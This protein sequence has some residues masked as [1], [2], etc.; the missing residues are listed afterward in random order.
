MFNVPSKRKLRITSDSPL[1]RKTTLGDLEV[2]LMEWVRSQRPRGRPVSVEDV[3]KQSNRL[4]ASQQ[5]SLKWIRG[6][7]SRNNFVYR[8]T[9]HVSQSSEVDPEVILEFKKFVDRQLTM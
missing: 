8:R 9:T 3:K 1:D 4:S 7:L 2:K 5:P 6:M